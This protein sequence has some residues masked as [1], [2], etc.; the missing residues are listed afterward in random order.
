MILLGLLFETA[1]TG[2]S[3]VS[4][5]FWSP[6][7]RTN[8]KTALIEDCFKTKKTILDFWIFKVHF[9]EQLKLT[10]F[11]QKQKYAYILVLKNLKTCFTKH[12]N[13]TL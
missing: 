6:A 13:G 5:V 9:L 2:E 4:T 3:L 12:M 10:D 1:L 7:N 11:F 8:G